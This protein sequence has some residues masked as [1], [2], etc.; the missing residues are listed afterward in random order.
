MGIWHRLLEIIYPERPHCLYCNSPLF[1]P[2]VTGL[3]SQCLS[4][5]EFIRSYCPCCGRESSTGGQ[6]CSICRGRSYYFKQARSVAVYNGVMRDLIL[7]FKYE[8][9]LRLQQ[10]LSD[11]LYLYFLHYYTNIS[12]DC[13]IPIPL[14]PERRRERG[15][16]QAEVLANLLG[17]RVNIPVITGI[18]QRAKNSL[19]LFNLGSEERYLAIRNSFKVIN[20]DLKGKSILL[21]DDIFTTGTTVNE[22]SR[23]LKK[24]GDVKTVYVLTLATAKLI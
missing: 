15:F 14:H 22:A 20:T 2:E 4:R 18:L 8:H 11:L 10:P 21:L 24:Q 12:I 17:K 7:R 19:P 3:C 1:F 9:N 23:V 13:I 5:I 16:N 6:L